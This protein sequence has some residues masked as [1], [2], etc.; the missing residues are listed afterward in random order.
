MA[1]S[2]HNEIH[3]GFDLKIAWVKKEKSEHC[4]RCN[5]IHLR[6]EYLNKC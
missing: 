4:I 3:V 1:F 6:F 2:E 5:R